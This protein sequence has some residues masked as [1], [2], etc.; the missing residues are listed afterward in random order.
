[1]TSKLSERWSAVA[2]ADLLGTPFGTIDT[3]RADF[4]SVPLSR[5]RQLSGA[6][7]RDCDFTAADFSELRLY[8]CQFINCVFDRA[9]FTN[10]GEH[11]CRF[12]R[13]SFVRTDWRVGAIG[14]RDHGQPKSQYVGC[15]FEKVRLARTIFQDARFENTHFIGPLKGVDF[16][17]CG[18]WSCCFTG[19]LDDVMFRGNY[20]YDSA[21]ERNPP[22]TETGLHDT[23]FADCEL[24]FIGLR[25]GCVLE[26]VE[27]PR[28]GEAF[29]CD[30]TR[31]MRERE[32][33]LASVSDPAVRENLAFYLDVRSYS[34]KHQPICIVS[35]KDLL[36]C[37]PKLEPPARA[38]YALLRRFA[39]ATQHQ[40]ATVH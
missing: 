5:L 30:Q 12:D 11:A 1:M 35:L 37:R 33:L 17:A 3:G 25:D 4:R 21:R 39:V 23:S 19:L 36:A 20:L 15:T 31:L 22:V 14:F 13:C 10:L 16:N 27:M 24:S 18:F 2:D 29:I 32:S 40:S 34:A 6:T 28:S 38:A 9:D 8:Q 26:N 7:F